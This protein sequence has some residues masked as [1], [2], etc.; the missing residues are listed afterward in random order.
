VVR[1]RKELR[2]RR[3]RGKGRVEERVWKCLSEA[4]PRQRLKP[5][6]K[7]LNDGCTGI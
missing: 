6:H 5:R 2:K 3:K 4:V 7:H 1:G